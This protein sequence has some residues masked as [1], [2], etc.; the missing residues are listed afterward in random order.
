M[1]DAAHGDHSAEAQQA[2]DEQARLAGR[3]I[4][5]RPVG[6]PERVCG[7]DVSYSKDESLA[8]GCAVVVDTETFEVVDHGLSHGVP[9][10]PYIPGLLSFRELPFIVD[11]LDELAVR[12]QLIV[13]DGHGYAHPA[14]LGLAS[15][16]GVVLNLPTIGCA[17]TPFIGHSQPPG[18]VKGAWEPIV[19]PS[20][21]DG[22][23][24]E[25]VGRV[26]RTRTGVKPVHVS[27]GHLIDLDSATAIVLA[28]CSHYRLPETTRQAD[29]R[30]RRV[31]A[32]L[33]AG[34]K[35]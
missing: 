12:P 33:T 20:V 22:G 11:A 4:L 1:Q 5:D 10:F 16:L 24:D 21:H 27:A 32:D 13:A 18:A 25:V 2:R 23:A 31:L 3:V 19:A 8:V 7:V 15:H 35:T 28:L 26:L 34:P 9:T 29:Q 17:K 14:R 30:S 6:L